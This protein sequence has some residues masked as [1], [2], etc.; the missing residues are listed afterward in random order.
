MTFSEAI[1]V[2]NVPIYQRIARRVGLKTYEVWLDRLGY[3][4][5]NPGTIVDRFW[6]DGPLTISA[7]EQT[8]FL[9]ALAL[10]ELPMSK[11]AQSAVKGMLLQKPATAAVSMQRPLA[12]RRSNRV[13]GWLGRRQWPHRH[14]CSEHGCAIPSRS[15]E[16]QGNRA[17]LSRPVGHIPGLMLKP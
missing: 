10:Q 12:R 15:S 16:A 13:V 3:G 5:A 4:N 1:R 7:I 2:S 8:S 17:G 6:L 9:A 11:T 14:L